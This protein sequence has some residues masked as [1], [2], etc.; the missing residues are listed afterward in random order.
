VLVIDWP[1]IN[2]QIAYGLKQKVGTRPTPDANNNATTAKVT[3]ILTTTINTT[4]TR[5]V[6]NN[7]KPLGKGAFI[8][9]FG[10]L[11]VSGKDNIIYL[12]IN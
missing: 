10:W 5:Q 7:K 9:C 4:L 8:I 12:K 3:A 2:T 6:C 1:A 11:T